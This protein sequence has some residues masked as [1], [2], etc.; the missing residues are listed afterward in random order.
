VEF[1]ASPSQPGTSGHHLD[2]LSSLNPDS[3]STK[4]DTYHLAPPYRP[5][6]A[7]D[8]TI[9][10]ALSVLR[11]LQSQGKI[12][13]IGISGYPLPVLLRISL[14]ALH[15]APFQPLDIIQTYA[16][17]TILNDSLAQGYLD[18]LT[19]KAG[20]G[21]LMNA[22]PLAMGLLTDSGGPL[23]HPL[24]QETGG[25][26]EATREAAELCR[27]RGAKLEVVA[28]E[29]GFR[30]L[31]Q[32]DGKL[33]P[34]VIGCKNMDEVTSTLESHRDANGEVKEV[35][36]EVMAMLE[37]KG[38]RGYSWANPHEDTFRD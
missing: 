1:V 28:S 30:E 3:G 29:F 2:A 19:E 14:V 7:G 9:L 21:Q 18:T 31:R 5:L 4:E 22:A 33:V 24:R 16:H 37:K 15:T 6:G 25:I 13:R 36:K 23:W 8:E 35:G 27:E 10:S 11:D 34:V 20:V 26:F 17:Q 38:V 32:K 12:R